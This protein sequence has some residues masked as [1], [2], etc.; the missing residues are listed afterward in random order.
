M[1]VI[2]DEPRGKHRLQTKQM[3]TLQYNMNNC[4]IGLYELFAEAPRTIVDI[5][6]RQK[7][8]CRY[9]KALALYLLQQLL[10][11]R[12]QRGGRCSAGGAFS[13][14]RIP[15]AGGQVRKYMLVANNLRDF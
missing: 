9:Y 2:A 10:S 1:L 7:S 6:R 12:K 8:R 14:A 5:Q 11:K 15:M 3:L 4:V 13:I